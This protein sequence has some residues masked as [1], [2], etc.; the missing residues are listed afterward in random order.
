MIDLVKWENEIRQ[1]GG[2]SGKTFDGDLKVA[3]VTEHAPTEIKL[4][5]QE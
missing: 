2:L 1:Y 3:L 5:I 4:H